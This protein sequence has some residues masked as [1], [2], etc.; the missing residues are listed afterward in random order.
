MPWLC[1]DRTATIRTHS[2]SFRQIAQQSSG[3]RRRFA[4]HS[5]DSRPIG[6]AALVDFGFGIVI[7]S[8]GAAGA[9]AAGGNQQ[10]RVGSRDCAKGSAAPP[11]SPDP[12]AGSGRRVSVAA[13]ARFARATRGFGDRERE[14]HTMEHHRRP[15]D[16]RSASG[17]RPRTIARLR[18]TPRLLAA[19]VVLAAV[20]VAG[21]AGAQEGA[22]VSAGP[23][24]L[25]TSYTFGE[26]AADLVARLTPAQR[27]SQL[28]SSQAPAITSVS[29][30]LLS[31]SQVGGSTTF[32]GPAAAG[33][34]N[35]K[36]ASV[37]GM[38]AGMPLILDSGSAAETV[39]ITTLGT[40]AATATTLPDRR[41]GRR[42]DDLRRERHRHDGRSP[43]PRRR[44]RDASSS[45]RCRPSAPLPRPRR[46]SWRRS[47][48][49]DDEHQ[50]RRASR[51]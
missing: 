37:A 47:A 44:G 38:V 23:I 30:P 8:R 22:A 32:A 25:D 6:L 10:G 36:V 39:T 7:R 50:G 33:D 2:R 31:P 24:Y 41:E 27:A 21:F 49:G 48:V 46:R 1:A 43:D 9:H 12:V 29:N 51:A 45:A 34:T 42:H 13:N 19:V 11:M 26:R 18:T 28:V 16:A 4:Q 40:A 15:T 17:R 14:E 3:I 20:L 5:R 35:V